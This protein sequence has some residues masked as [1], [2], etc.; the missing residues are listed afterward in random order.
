[1]N[2]LLLY[3]K[4]PKAMK[5]FFTFVFIVLLTGCANDGVQ[6]IQVGIDPDNTDVIINYDDPGIIFYKKFSDDAAGVY[7]ED[8]L[9]NDWNC[10]SWNNGISEHRASLVVEDDL[11][12]LSVLYPIDSFGSKNSG[13]QWKLQLEP[14]EELYFAYR[15]KFPESFD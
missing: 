7:N 1:M 11:T 5:L 3:R 12:V 4:I 2:Y 13:C 9:C 14:Y 6:N 15:I 10:P 8:A